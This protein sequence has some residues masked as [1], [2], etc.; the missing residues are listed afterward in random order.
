MILTL[1][2]I[3]ITLMVIAIVTMC[4]KKKDLT[5]SLLWLVIII[6]SL[7]HINEL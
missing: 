4:K 1:K 3:N 2:L 6:N 7:I 5:I